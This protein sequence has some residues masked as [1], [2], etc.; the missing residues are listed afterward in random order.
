MNKLMT[1]LITS[2]IQADQREDI[3]E[4]GGDRRRY[5][6]WT[7]REERSVELL[8]WNRGVS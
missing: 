2:W 8:E 7:G 6:H 4:E 3:W 1:A 5:R